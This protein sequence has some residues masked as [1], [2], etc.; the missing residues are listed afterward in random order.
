MSRARGGKPVRRRPRARLIAVVLL[1]LLLIGAGAAAYAFR[2]LPLDRPAPLE[3]QPASAARGKYLATLGNCKACHTAPG[4]AAFAGG[5]KFK[6]P[7]GVLYST[8]ITPHR[9]NG[10]G[11]WTFRDFHAAMKHG[12]RPDGSH[13]Y[14]A[15]PYTSFAKL[16][17]GDIASLFLYFRT[18]RPSATANRENRFLFPFGE[19]R[20]LYFWK[21]MFHED[22]PFVPDDDRSE[23]WNRGAYLVEAVAH[24]GACHTPRNVLGAPD[25][26][27][28]LQGGTY[29]DQVASGAYRTWSAVDLT[30]GP[31]GLAKWSGTDIALYLTRGKNRH[32]VVHGPMNEVFAS[33]R[34]L[35]WEDAA[36]IATYLKS[37]DPS[38]ERLDLSLFRSGLDEG[39]IVYTVHCGT[40]HLPDGKGDKVLGV[41]LV[42]NPI[43][44]AKD[45]AALINVILYG[46]ELPPAPF[47]SDRT[48]MKPF[49]K[50]LSDNDVAALATYLRSNF[51]NNASAVSPGDVRRQR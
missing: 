21:R 46:P 31:H 36:A 17:D 4:K 42:R 38:T 40:C 27:R 26:S 16:S 8:N 6:T 9:G 10:I 39:E 50:R 15:F 13:L 24:C 43:V 5:A 22:S 34:H 20:L 2:P 32:A 1:I 25:E 29:T 45:P 30:P 12:M 47:V 35:R 14:P 49:G 44:Q 37:V 48:V 3:Q 7:F 23:A 51:G 28:A 33:T 18:V 19:R 11:A 41:S